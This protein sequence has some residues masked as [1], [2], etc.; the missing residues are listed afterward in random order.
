MAAQ[1]ELGRELRASDPA[2]AQRLLERVFRLTSS[3]NHPAFHTRAA[4]SLSSVHFACSEREQ[5]QRYAEAAL[6]A[7]LAAGSRRGQAVA[8]ATIGIVHVC[9]CDYERARDCCERS[10]SLSRETGYLHA[11]RLA[12]NNLAA[13]AGKLGNTEESI[14]LFRELLALDESAHDHRGRARSL[15]ALAWSLHRAGRVDEAAER[16]YRDVEL[17]E[18]YGIEDTRLLALNLLGGLYELRGD[19]DRERQ[20][21]GQVI[22]AA[23]ETGNAGALIPALA[24]LGRSLVETGDLAAGRQCLARALAASERAGGPESFRPDVLVALAQLAL[25]ENRCTESQTLLDEAEQLASQA[26]WPLE[27]GLALA[28]RALLHVHQ[29]H[30][31][32]A[33]RCFEQAAEAYA[34]VGD[35]YDLARVRLEW[36]SWLARTGRPEAA[37]PLVEQAMDSAR[38]L[39]AT[40]I[41]EQATRLLFDLRK[42]TDRETALLEGLAGMAALKLEPVTALERMC[43]LVSKALGFEGAAVLLGPE[44]VAVFGRPDL[45]RAAELSR[46]SQPL[47]TDNFLLLV[48]S[49]GGRPAGS[50][51]FG[52]KTPADVALSPGTVE[53]MSCVFAE[54]LA[55]IVQAQTRLDAV[56]TSIPGLCFHGIVGRSKAMLDYLSLVRRLAASDMPVLLRGESG[57]GKELA[58][59]ALHDSSP[60]WNQPFVAVNCAAVPEGLLEA[61]FFGVAR[62]AATGV[63]QRRGKFELADKGTIFLD[64]I[65]D[66]SLGLQA[67]LL[68]VLQEK[69]FEHVGGTTPVSVDVRVV[70]ATNQDLEG[71]MKDRRFREDLYFRLNGCE[72]N[73]P[74]LRDR[75]EDIPVFA[76]HFIAQ[77]CT[78]LGRSLAGPEPGFLERLIR[79]DWPGNI[80]ELRNTIERSVLMAKGRTLTEADLPSGLGPPEP[81]PT[82][83]PGAQPSTSRS[84]LKQMAQEEERKF[85]LECLSKAKWN[86]TAAAKLAGFGRTRF[87]ELLRKHGLEQPRLRGK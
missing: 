28:A 81:G 18:Q 41:A 57:T 59:R 17:C 36:G 22:A 77:S 14:G 40:V 70:A 60:R 80:R 62:G 75:K 83:E 11:A 27:R 2:K 3:E 30:A 82:P 85:L 49:V 58:A 46:Q 6:R 35:N 8:W 48:L 43:E 32:D 64:E 23:S 34:E 26:G 25:A 86:V 5:Q 45:N 71:R 29:G 78:R 20:L 37:I 87:Y 79:H 72:V 65:A 16:L 7:A 4:T 76:R 24:N 61:E 21:L 10:L 69:V 50:A 39:G 63:A 55:L 1:L 73:I 51:W 84:L 53:H 44:P 38:R 12:L 67:R 74:A 66:M 68:R 13:I 42:Q 52:R 15:Y 9:R 31:A 47:I 19:I 33:Q 54:P 56:P